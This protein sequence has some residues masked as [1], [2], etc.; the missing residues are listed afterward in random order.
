M[1][2]VDWAETVSKVELEAELSE[3]EDDEEDEGRHDV[4]RTVEYGTVLW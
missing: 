2:R 3:E 1:D 4:E